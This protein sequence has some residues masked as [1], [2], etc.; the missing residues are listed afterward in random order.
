MSKG[1]FEVLL[2]SDAELSPP[3]INL[4]GLPD[5]ENFM[6]ILS[7]LWLR[8]GGLPVKVPGRSPWPHRNLR[9]TFELA[10]PNIQLTMW[11]R[12]GYETSAE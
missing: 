7:E 4:G 9:E 5:G 3:A 10:K 11:E 12:K 1:L 8:N 2:E 6:S